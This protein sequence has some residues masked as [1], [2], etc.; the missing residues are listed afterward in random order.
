MS[1][2][3]LKNFIQIAMLGVFL[4]FA[5]LSYAS[6]KSIAS[7]FEL[8][9]VDGKVSLSDF[10]N[11]VVILYFGYTFCPDICPTSLARISAA[12]KSLTAE[13]QAQIQPV[14][15]SLDPE[16]DT[17]QNLA[18][19]V[20]FFLPSFIGLTGTEQE[21]ARVAKNYR[22]LF[23]KTEVEDGLDYVIDHSSI[24]FV[25]GRD[26]QLF[27]HLLHD[28]TPVEIAEKLRMALAVPPLEQPG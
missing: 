5:N 11:K 6:V 22:I 23:R 9:S 10:R 3:N 24:Y 2:I 15:I 27:S 4:L 13:E 7:D 25:I 21:I 16:R 28:V 1:T 18:D 20:T 19:Y 12:Y 26:G 8:Y 14:F 17:K